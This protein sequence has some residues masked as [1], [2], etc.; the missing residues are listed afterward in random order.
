MKYGYLVVMAFLFIAYLSLE[1]PK[2]NK[3]VIS[4]M[5]FDRK[6]AVR[7]SFERYQYDVIFVIRQN[8]ALHLVFD[9]SAANRKEITITH[10]R[11]RRTYQLNIWPV[12]DKIFLNNEEKQFYK[13]GVFEIRR[14]QIRKLNDVLPAYV[15]ENLN[16]EIYIENEGQLLIR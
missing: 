12:N 10:G 4:A 15:V 6:T 8:E 2:S 13:T 1:E 3:P 11:T 14:D 9:E 5:D 7:V 16:D